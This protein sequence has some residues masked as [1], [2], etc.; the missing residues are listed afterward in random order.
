LNG[1]RTEAIKFNELVS[2][3]PSINPIVN[4]M[5][6][7]SKKIFIKTEKREVLITRTKSVRKIFMFCKNCQQETEFLNLEATTMQT[8]IKTLDLINLIEKDLIHWT[9]NN[10]GFL[11]ICRNSLKND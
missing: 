4:Q 8:T 6:T 9:E 10:D 5:P 1:L 11:L 7:K 2:L 3:F